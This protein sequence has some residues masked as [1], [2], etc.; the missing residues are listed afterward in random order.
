VAREACLNRADGRLMTYYIDMVN[1]AVWRD[2]LRLF[3]AEIL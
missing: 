1:I 2:H 3:I